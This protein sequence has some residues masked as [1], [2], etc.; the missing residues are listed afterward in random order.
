MKLAEQ[1]VEMYVSILP[2][3]VP[4]PFNSVLSAQRK[5]KTTTAQVEMFDGEMATMYF[6]H[7]HIMSFGW[8]ELNSDITYENGQWMRVNAG[9]VTVSE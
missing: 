9:L 4:V 2:P 1:V 5:G 8:L 7:D 6:E 3:N